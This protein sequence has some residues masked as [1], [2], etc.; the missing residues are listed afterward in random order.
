MSKIK[1]LLAE[2]EDI[3]DLKPIKKPSLE[4]VVD[5]VVNWAI[6][7]YSEDYI[8]DNAEFG[9]VADDDDG[10]PV[11]VMENFTSLCDDLAVRYLDRLIEGEHI[12][13]SDDDYAKALDK[14]SAR[15]ADFYSDY[16]DSLCAS[17]LSDYNRDKQT[18]NEEYKERHGQC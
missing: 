14:A 2:E 9:M 15:I 12:D 6:M 7:P 18:L 3:E 16:E 17:E 1:D 13:I 11:M 8:A 4:W 10:H 5:T